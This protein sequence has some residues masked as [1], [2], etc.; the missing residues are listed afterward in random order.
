MPT[1]TGWKKSS[2]LNEYCI[3]AFLILE[4][5]FQTLKI[6]DLD[7]CLA[8]VKTATPF[9]E[10]VNP[11]LISCER[12]RISEMA[13]RIEAPPYIYLNIVRQKQVDVAP[14]IQYLNVSHF[15]LQTAP[16]TPPSHP[17]PLI[18]SG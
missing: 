8:V 14:L 4:T 9:T 17:N 3:D 5:H 16:Q 18:G 7:T 11:G 12:V 13:I 15:L 6:S 1:P 10:P 2:K